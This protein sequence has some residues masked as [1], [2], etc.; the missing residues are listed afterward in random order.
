MKWINKIIG[1]QRLLIAVVALMLLLQQSMF[2][3]SF[4]HQEDIEKRVRALTPQDIPVLQD[5]ARSG[6]ATSQYM[7]GRAYHYGY[8]VARNYTEALKWYRKAAEQ[9]QA[10]AQFFL[11]SMY[12]EGEGVPKDIGKAMEWLGRSAEGGFASGQYLFGCSIE[13][14]QGD[15]GE[16]LK[17]YRKAAEQGH[18]EAQN[19]LGFFY[20][21]GRGVRQDF[22]EAVNWYHKAA[23]QGNAN[24]QSNLGV[25]YFFGRGITKD[26]KEATKW[27]RMAAEQGWVAGQANL[28]GA[29]MLGQGVPRDLVSAYMWCTLAAAQGNSECKQAV[30][31][32]QSKMKPEEIAEAKHQA[33]VWTQAHPKTTKALDQPEST[34][35]QTQT[36]EFPMNE[37]HKRAVELATLLE[38]DPLSSNAKG[39]RKEMK[40]MISEELGITLLVC[41]PALG[42]DLLSKQQ[43]AE[44]LL[45]QF[46][47]TQAKFI[48]QH[49]DKAQNLDSVT[50]ASI[51][52]VLRAYTVIKR[53]KSNVRLIELEDLLQKQQSGL[54]EA[55]VKS[56]VVACK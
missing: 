37:K 24:A 40:R 53:A 39:W 50:T 32:L 6:D 27:Y 43:Y 34:K 30:N 16:A 10:A 7:L 5:K 51:E 52:G 4:N 1:F 56:I 33:T 8:G 46:V 29:Y 31:F 54:L 44:D 38:N 13:Q 3:F 28:A 21:Q 12:S 11:F 35:S 23:E 42:H 19:A 17:W 49:P 9:G 36:E 15:Y 20:E 14:L 26:F 25:M 45:S 2:A 41:V 48:I 55:H 18:A 47:Y 22:K